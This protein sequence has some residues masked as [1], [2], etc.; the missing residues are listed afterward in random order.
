MEKEYCKCAKYS[1]E[2]I[3]E[4]VG[5]GYKS[6]DYRLSKTRRFRFI[7]NE[8]GMIYDREIVNGTIDSCT[9]KADMANI[10]MQG[11]VTGPVTTE[12]HAKRHAKKKGGKR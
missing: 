7:K 11:I 8:E 9:L 2:A 10:A 12:R 3:M 5:N 6:E 1:C 4:H